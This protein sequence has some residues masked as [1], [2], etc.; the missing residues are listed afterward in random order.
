M[1][2]AICPTRH[3]AIGGVAQ[4]RQAPDSMLLSQA[5]QARWAPLGRLMRRSSREVMVL[6]QR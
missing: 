5:R 3:Q 4:G 1:A 2:H 6:A